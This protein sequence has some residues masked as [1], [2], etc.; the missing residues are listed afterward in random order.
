MLN[1]SLHPLQ[2]NLLLET[3]NGSCGYSFIRCIGLTPLGSWVEVPLHFRLP[4]G[5]M[6]LR[7]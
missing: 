4:R 6:G 5:G 3:E 7:A 1:S 2:N